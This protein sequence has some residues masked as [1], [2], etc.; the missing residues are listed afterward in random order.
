[1][2]LPDSYTQD[3]VAILDS[4]TFEQLFTAAQP[5]RV[6]VRDTKRATKFEV[7]DGTTRS[8]H[9]VQ[10]QIEIS[11]DVL[12]QDEDA[13]DA[14]QQ[15]RQAKNDNRLVIVQTKVNS[16]ESMLI[17]EIPHDET[18]E[19]GGAISVPMR[20]VEWRTVTPQYGALPPTKVKNKKQ[21]STSKGGQKQTTE[22]SSTGTNAPVNRKASVLFGVFN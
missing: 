20:L 15:I 17:T 3:L 22:A 13:R 6:S 1:M 19:L 4:E 12:L 16:Y 18:V 10:D 8:D 2:A 5:M 7:E 11:I 21:A 9:V 14:Y